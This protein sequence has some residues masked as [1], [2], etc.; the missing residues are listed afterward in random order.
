[1]PKKITSTCLSLF[2]AVAALAAVASPA[3]AGEASSGTST[4]PVAARLMQVLPSGAA[5][6]AAR[7]AGS[8]VATA[9]APASGA[10]QPG[11]VFS[12]VGVLCRL[13]AGAGPESAVDVRASLDGTHWRRWWRLGFEDVTGPGA[14]DAGDQAA[15]EPLWIGQ[16]R[17]LQYRLALAGA[18][19]A[20]APSVTDLRV[21]F[22]APALDS[23]TT[24][25]AERAARATAAQ[26]AAGAA[27]GGAV[28][29]PA[30]V[31]RAQWGANESWCTGSPEYCPVRMV[32]VHHTDGPNDYTR[33]QAP[34]IVRGIYY[35]HARVLHWGDI[36]YNFLIDRYG[37]IYEGRKGGIAKGVVGAQT[38]GF[39]SGSTGVSMMGGFMN[40]A[41]PAAAIAALK[42]L[43]TWKLDVHHIYPLGQTTMTCAYAEKF[44][45]GQ[46]VT[47]LVISG[48]RQACYTSCPGDKLF[49]LLPQIRKAVAATGLPKIYSF[50][51]GSS[52]L[53]PNG[54]G[55]LDDLSIHYTISQAA[56]W[57]V[58]IKAASGAVVRTFKGQGDA[59]QVTW[60]GRN[61]GGKVVADGAYTVVATATCSRGTARPGIA[62]VHVDTAPPQAQQLAPSPATISPNGDGFADVCALKYQASESCQVRFSVLSTGLKVLRQ[63]S[64]WSAHAAGNGTVSWDGKITSGAKLVAA[65]DGQYV[66]EL[67]LK[68]QAGNVGRARCRVHVNRTLGFAQA[69][70]HV[71]SPNGDGRADHAEL[72]FRLTRAAKVTVVVAGAHGVVRTFALGTTAPGTSTTVWDGRDH[73]GAVVP[74]GGYTFT[75]TATNGLGSVTVAGRVIVDRYAPRITAPGKATATKGHTVALAYVVKDPYSTKAHVRVSVTTADGSTLQTIDC[76]WVQ[77]G[78]HQEVSYRPTVVGALTVTF[79]ARDAGQNDEYAP[80]T[81]ALNVKK[82]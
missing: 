56:D 52:Y 24:A 15:T 80:A 40:V 67:D 51:L 43:L 27:A 2:L 19:A 77:T 20:T 58:Q 55:R 9:V 17:Y 37:T 69:A 75:A 36:G 73:S 26:T 71:I 82:P 31:T 50:A 39:N 30:I 60:N 53:S 6:P 33:A 35:Y 1:M 8:R 42:R 62:T 44:R 12:M 68:D 70:P 18:G 48:H 16:A 29:Q 81:T 11:M 59:V 74:S 46:K 4:P 78:V 45:L 65:P 28:P 49:A 57:T 64:G 32:F 54:D 38:L 7:F 63:V 66:L 34:G 61:G 72:S 5:L 10:L 79:R 14:A 41:P 23:T 25:A 47:F 21:S 3:T 76:G 13:P 22:L